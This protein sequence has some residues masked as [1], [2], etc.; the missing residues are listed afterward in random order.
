MEE[1]LEMRGT[2][3]PALNPLIREYDGLIGLTCLNLYTI[4]KN[5]KTIRLYSF[6]RH[7]HEHLYLLRIALLARDL[8]DF[9]LEIESSWW[10]VLRLN[11]KIRKGFNKIGRIKSQFEGGIQTT[12]MLNFMRP[13]GIERCGRNFSFADIYHEYYEG[14][15]D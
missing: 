15:L 7:N 12:E 3:T 13:D 9:N 10:D 2:E 14:S 5:T 4:A 1:N 11:W 6:D 8:Y